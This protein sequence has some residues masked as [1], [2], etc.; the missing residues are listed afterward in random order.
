MGRMNHEA[1]S[2]DSQT[3]YVYQTEDRNDSVYYRFVPRKKPNGFGD[4]QQGGE[5]YAMVTNTPS[6]GTGGIVYKLEFFVPEPGTGL[7]IMS[8]MGV[9]VRRRR[10]RR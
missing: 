5:L 1:V 8:V 7:M 6:N 10:E 2:V 3:G 4:L 9:F